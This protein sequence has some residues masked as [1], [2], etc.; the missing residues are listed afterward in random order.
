M[1]YTL[2]VSSNIIKAKRPWDRCFP[3]NFEKFLRTPFL[4]NISGRLIL[5][6]IKISLELD[7][8]IPT[9]VLRGKLNIRLPGVDVDGSYHKNLLYTMSDSDIHFVLQGVL[10]IKILK[11]WIL[12]TLIRACENIFQYSS[13]ELFLNVVKVNL[14]LSWKYAMSYSVGDKAKGWISKRTC[15]YQGAQNVRFSENLACFIFLEHPFWDLPFCLNSGDRILQFQAIL[16]L[17][18]FRTTY[19]TELIFLHSYKQ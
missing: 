19:L 14:L 15:A 12:L 11:W 16:S 2:H 10:K 17:S 7:F 9:L 18:F 4:Q 6:E 13:H 1:L 3:V 8:E 5:N